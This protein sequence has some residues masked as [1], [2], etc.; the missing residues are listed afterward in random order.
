[1]LIIPATHPGVE[2]NT[3]TF[4]DATKSLVEPKDGAKASIIKPRTK[5]PTSD[6]INVSTAHVIAVPIGNLKEP[7]P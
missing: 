6:R 5:T 3:A 1:M 4:S 7:K 2:E